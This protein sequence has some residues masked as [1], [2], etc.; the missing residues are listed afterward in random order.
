MP[1]TFLHA[2]PPLGLALAVDENL[3]GSQLLQELLLDV[4]GFDP[5]LLLLPARH[6]VSGVGR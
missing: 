3:G 4:L 2:P 5:S 1:A 6:R